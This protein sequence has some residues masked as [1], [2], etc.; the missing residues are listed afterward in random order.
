MKKTW[1]SIFILLY[2]GLCTGLA[3]QPV[4]VMVHGAWGGAWQFAAV[5]RMMEDSGVVVHRVQLTGLGE[6][7]HLAHRG[8]D[9]DL[10]IE[11]VINTIWFEGLDAVVL[12]GHSYGG[13]VITGVAERIPEKIQKL[14][15]LDAFLPENNQSVFDLVDEAERASLENNARDG[16]VIPEWA[17]QETIVPRDMPQP[18][19][20]LTQRISLTNSEKRL[21]I[22]SMYILTVDQIESIEE[23]A[24]FPFYERAK[25]YGW[26]TGLM[27]ADHNPQRSKPEELAT[28][29]LNER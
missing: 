14:I 4:Y 9:L 25:T 13:M 10:H 23:D 22:P 29:L 11:D 21:G 7:Y 6:R 2:L 17:K 24:F 26:T 20:T 12:V 5:D 19:A 28:M 1:F 3:K 18:L 16:F 15:Y 8:I 27:V